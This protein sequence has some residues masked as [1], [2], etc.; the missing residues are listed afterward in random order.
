MTSRLFVAAIV[1]A[2]ASIAFASA[3]PPPSPDAAPHGIANQA[4]DEHHD[5]KAD[6]GPVPVPEPSEKALHYARTGNW[7]WSFDQLWGLLVPGVILFTGFSARLRTWAQRIGKNWYFTIVLYVITFVVGI[8][9]SYFTGY[10]RPHAYDLSNQ[11]FGK[12][13]GDELKGLMVGAVFGVLFL[14]VPYLLIKKSP[15]RWWLWTAL[16]AIPFSAFVLL[17]EPVAI[18]PL[19]N[20][21]GPM[22]DKALEQQILTLAG[23]AGIEGARVFE[24]DKSTDTKTVNAYV[25]GFG[26]SKRIVLWD[27]TI[28]KLEPNQLLFVMGHEMGH[29]VLGHVLKTIFFASVLILI[30]LYVFDRLQAGVIA[31]YRERFGFTQLAD[32]AS[33]PLILLLT[34]ILSFV[35]TPIAAGYSRWQEHEADRFGLEITHDNHAAASAFVRLQEENLSVPRRSLLYKLWR[36]DHPLLGERID[37]C[38]AYHPWTENQP[39]KYEKLFH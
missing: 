29:Y 18:E 14:W 17:I 2:I 13:A 19:F 27:T 36:A 8:P 39:G 12:W 22:K 15:R 24:V 1:L 3:A 38:N 4:S 21:F 35:I 10:V 33:L 20:T 7:I 16:V 5:Q 31:R 11:T 32:V 26:S 9:W 25:T 28:A 23:R 37:F 6:T 30:T 34:G